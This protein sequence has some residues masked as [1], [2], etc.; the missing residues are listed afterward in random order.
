MDLDRI[1]GATL[2]TAGAALGAELSPSLPSRALL[3]AL[4]ALRDGDFSVRLPSDLTGIAGKI[5][6]TFNE[7]AAISDRRAQ[8]TARVSRA[9]GK[10]GKL[11]E[12]MN[13]PGVAGGWADEV[14]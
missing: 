10:E 6:D 5:A 1:G 7:I 13:V 2:D 11:R 9:V 14:S 4:L 12:R 3:H 8:E